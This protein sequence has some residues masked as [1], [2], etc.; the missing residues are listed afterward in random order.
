MILDNSEK[1]RFDNLE[2]SLRV[3]VDW[4]SFTFRPRKN[5]KID[6]AISLLG[7]NIDD[8]LNLPKGASGYCSALQLNGANIR[9]LYDGAIGMGIHVDVS[10]SAISTLLSA[11]QKK[12]TCFTP[13]D[14]DATEYQE[15]EYTLLLDLLDTLSSIATFTRI[16]LAIDDIGSNY[17]SCD[18]VVTLIENH[19]I[20]SKFRTYKTIAPCLLNDGT[21]QGHT[22]YIGSRASEVM[23][24]IYDKKLEFS[25][26]H[27]VNCPLEWVRWELEL[28]KDRADQ[29][30]KLLLKTHSL[31][32]VCIGILNNY[33]R[34]KENDNVNPSR[35]TTTRIWD[36]FINGME[37]LS[38]YVPDNPKTI[39]DIRLWIDTYVGPSLCAVIET[40]GGS[41]DFIYENL[42][43]WQKKRK[44]NRKLTSR[45]NQEL[46]KE[47]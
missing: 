14:A 7:F 23:L 16:D 20:V 18:D 9:I 17:Y 24:R 46:D 37:K 26:K 30:V 44:Q 32:T 41:L 6:D 31:S 33:I 43:K 40:D 22:I 45:L 21:K 10:G 39:E 12:H 1:D 34:F 4:L 38:L 2:N 42:P 28:K 3:C 36:D 13:F 29:T 19:Q 15:I 11:W 8:F 25:N 35:C 5:F 47:N 27:N